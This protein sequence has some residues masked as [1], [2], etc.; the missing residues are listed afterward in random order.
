MINAGI[1]GFLD[2]LLTEKEKK[3]FYKE[4]YEFRLRN[5]R[6]SI[7]HNKLEFDNDVL[8]DNENFAKLF[9]EKA[10]KLYGRYGRYK[11]RL[12]NIK[13][14]IVSYE[15]TINEKEIENLKK[16]ITNEWN[17]KGSFSLL[18]KKYEVHYKETI[19]L[20]SELKEKTFNNDIKE[21]IKKID[22]LLAVLNHEPYYKEFFENEVQF[23]LSNYFANAKTG[24]KRQSGFLNVSVKGSKKDHFYKNIIEP[25]I[26][27]EVKYDK[28]NRCVISG[29]QARQKSKYDSGLVPFFGHPGSD[30]YFWLDGSK[31]LPLNEIYELIYWCSFA[32]FTNISEGKN[33]RFLFCNQDSSIVDL[34]SANR[35]LFLKFSKT[36][37]KSISYID[38][39]SDLIVAENQKSTYKLQNT[40]LV[41]IQNFGESYPKI[42]SLYISRET[43][44]FLQEEEI[45]KK[46]NSLSKTKFKYN[47]SQNN[48]GAV[49]LEKILHNHLNYDFLQILVKQALSETKEALY[50]KNQ[51]Q[52][53]NYIILSYFQKIK[54]KENLM[55]Q[56][57]NYY[58]YGHG[59]KLALKIKQ[60]N[61]ENKIKGLVHKFLMYQ[62]TGDI[63]SFLNLFMRIHMAYGMQTPAAVIK[64]M[65]SEAGFN[66][67]GYSFING[68]LNEI[69]KKDETN[70]NNKDGE[71]NE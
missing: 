21:L 46:L 36:S 54:M 13:K 66:A 32:G 6:I 53:V 10:F 30:N 45:F 4:E 44:V 37:E 18:E 52:N 9:F 48:I 3:Q 51:L 39:L 62:K 34:C 14:L 56:E 29:E 22:N 17:Y 19:K 2:I 63:N 58:V 35:K 67:F 1:I 47:D 64:S 65:N 43:A 42:H 68:L 12:Q 31:E 38:F 15:K 5:G 57:E 25:I 49:I 20:G 8:A 41:D 23:Y 70:K 50:I 71:N 7:S 59:G 60:Q 27:N 33:Y 11:E 69:N 26:S 16:Q 55:S 24:I 28:Q 61:H 40:A